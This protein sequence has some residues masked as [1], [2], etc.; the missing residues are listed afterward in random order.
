[1][2]LLCG[3]CLL[4]KLAPFRWWRRTLGGPPEQGLKGNGLTLANAAS[5]AQLIDRAAS[6]LPFNVRCL[7]RALVLSWLLRHRGV[8]HAV[9]FAVRP[10]HL[11]QAPDALHA[12]LEMN[13]VTLLGDLPGPWIEIL[14]LGQEQV[15]RQ[16]LVATEA[17]TEHSTDAKFPVQRI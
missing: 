1:M 8:D 17:K 2:P 16:R 5:L 4:V 15:V 11:R 9:V 14:R 13:G 6:R 10:K 7:P 12:W 3:A